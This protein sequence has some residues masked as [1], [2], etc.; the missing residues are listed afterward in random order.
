M[1]Y[2]TEKAVENA[3][4]NHI[5]RKGSQFC[6]VCEANNQ[7]Q[8]GQPV[9]VAGIPHILQCVTTVQQAP[10]QTG[11]LRGH[12]RRSRDASC[13]AWHCNDYAHTEFAC[14]EWDCR[15]DFKHGKFI[16]LASISLGRQWH[17][18]LST[19]FIITFWWRIRSPWT[20]QLSKITTQPKYELSA[21][22][23]GTSTQYIIAGFSLWVMDC[24][25]D[26]DVF[27]MHWQCN[28]SMDRKLPLI[29]R[30]SLSQ[31]Q[32]SSLSGQLTIPQAF[33]PSSQEHRLGWCKNYFC[34]NPLSC[35]PPCHEWVVRSLKRLLKGFSR[36]AFT[37]NLENVILQS[38]FARFTLLLNK[39]MKYE[40]KQGFWVENFSYRVK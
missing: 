6:E 7:R 17:N 33:K 40:I 20:E 12:W 26:S 14:N 39:W 36:K 38:S 15:R 27:T 35:L 31:F 9:D 5:Q 13:F 16:S 28:S 2:L 10:C 22:T 8:T 24:S 19:Q 18:L 30:K 29:Y 4:G 23:Q 25:S 34:N 32:K 3:A 37:E 11:W 1:I 21:S